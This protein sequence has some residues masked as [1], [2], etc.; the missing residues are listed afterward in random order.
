MKTSIFYCTLRPLVQ[1]KLDVLGKAGLT[2][3]DFSDADTK[4][5]TVSEL[6]LAT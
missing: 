4:I 6:P 5:M 3:D 1:G 2:K